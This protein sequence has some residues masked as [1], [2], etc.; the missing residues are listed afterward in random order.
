VSGSDRRIARRVRVVAAVAALAVWVGPGSSARGATVNFT[1]SLDGAQETTCAMSS[2][3]MGAATVTLDDVSGMLSWSITFGNNSPLFNNGTLD[4]GAETAAHFHGPAPA[5]MTAGIKVT[6]T[7]GSPKIG[8]TTITA[9]GD[10]TDIKND[11]W[12][13]NIH[14]TGCFGGEIRGQVV[15]VPTCG[16]GIL[17]GGEQCDDGNT[18]GGDCCDATCQLEP[19]GSPCDDGDPETGDDMCT[20]GSCAGA[21]LF[22]FI[23]HLIP[24]KVFLY[25]PGKKIKVISKGTFTLPD[26]NSDP[27]EEGGE[28]TFSTEADPNG[29][30]FALDSGAWSTVG[31]PAAPKGFKAKTTECKRVL[32]KGNIIKAICSAP[33]LGTLPIDPNNPFSAVLRVGT[34]G[35]TRYCAECGG[36]VKGNPSKL[37]KRKN[38]SEPASCPGAG[39]P[40][41][42]F[43]EP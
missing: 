3:A 20:A 32:I 23:D 43:V 5:G 14:S 24:V 18:T 31:S 42:A 22:T 25:K 2:T 36:E 12:Y 9:A 33:D 38:C 34:N 17:D 21:P 35:G 1:S 16:D 11:L 28:L 29:A 10:R 7:S 19:D 15:R 41:G 30:T 4:F 6:L 8:S 39:S 13:I 40:S 26:P 37:A 27:T